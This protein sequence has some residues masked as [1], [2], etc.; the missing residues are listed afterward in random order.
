MRLYGRGQSQ[1]AHDHQV[2]YLAFMPVDSDPI[3]RVAVSFI[4]ICQTSSI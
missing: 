3:Q 1:P 2:I 4:H